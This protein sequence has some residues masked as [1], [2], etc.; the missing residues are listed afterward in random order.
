MTYPIDHCQRLREGA[1]AAM[2]NKPPEDKARILNL[3]EAI[4]E[5]VMT[6]AQIVDGLE[7]DTLPVRY[8]VSVRHDVSE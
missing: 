3:L 6:P 8:V 4:I 7:N 2:S 1:L 5:G